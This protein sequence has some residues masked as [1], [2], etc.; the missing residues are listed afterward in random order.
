MNHHEKINDVEFPANNL[1]AVKAFFEKAF[2][3]VF[4]DYGPDYAAFTNVGL[5]GGFF[6]SEQ[7]ASTDNGSALIVF[8]S[9]ALE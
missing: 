5:E 9:E 3:W 1:T 4:T 6:G 7:H 8:Y 2:G